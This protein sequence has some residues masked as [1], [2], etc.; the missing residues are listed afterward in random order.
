MKLNFNSKQLDD[1]INITFLNLKDQLG[2]PDLKDHQEIVEP[3]DL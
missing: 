3:V 2:H 1:C